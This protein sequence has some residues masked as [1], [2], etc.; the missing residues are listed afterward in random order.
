[1]PCKCNE[2]GGVDEPDVSQ[3]ISKTSLSAATSLA[4]Y[5]R[6]AIVGAAEPTHGVGLHGIDKDGNLFGPVAGGAFERPLFKPACA[7]RNSCQGHPVLACRTHWPVADKVPIG[8]V[9]GGS[10]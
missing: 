6:A 4:G 3:V 5:G 8:K 10:A 1:M 2:T 9:K 7:G